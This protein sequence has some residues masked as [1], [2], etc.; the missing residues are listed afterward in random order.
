[1]RTPNS[2]TPNTTII[3]PMKN[4]IL[5]LAL[6]TGAASLFVS[7]GNSKNAQEAQLQ[8]PSASPA[9]TVQQRI[10]VTDVQVVYGRPSMRGRKVFGGLEPYGSVW[11][12]GANNATTVSFSTDVT[13]GDKE[14]PAGEYSLFSIPGE[15]EWT[16]ILNKSA[17][18]FG[19]YG[20]DESM[21]IARTKVRS[22][23]LANAVE[24]FE[25]GFENLRS[26]GA[27]MALEWE[28]ARVEVPIK[29]N[30]VKTLAPQIER[31][32]AGNGEKP[33]F[34]AAMFY[35]ENDLDMNKAAAWIEEGV[36]AQPTA[37]WMV[38]RQ[39]LILAK[40]GDKRGAIAAAEA[41]MKM[42]AESQGGA[43]LKAEY[44]RLNEALIARLKK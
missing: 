22:K 28:H 23:K 14:V 20:Y 37:F 10:G 43:S 30:V 39:G 27:T 42:A 11:R 29:T 12:T 18:Q 36:K 21:D 4:T 13:F 31:V 9:A 38:Y 41:S 16:V 2:T 32:M 24:T 3:A 25:I 19:A 5:S 17:A 35:Y 8:F 6:L 15:N 44:K 1:M 34:P 33:Y 40:K 26:T 7:T